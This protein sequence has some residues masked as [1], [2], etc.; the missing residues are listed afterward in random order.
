[1]KSNKSAKEEPVSQQT[2]EM[3]EEALK[4]AYSIIENVLDHLKQDVTRMEIHK[5][6]LKAKEIMKECLW[7]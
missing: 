2:P 4:R 7:T 1:M 5:K 6:L 3:K